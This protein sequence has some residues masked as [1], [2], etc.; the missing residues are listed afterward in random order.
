MVDPTGK[1]IEE[2]T[3]DLRKGR[4]ST[5]AQTTCNRA[6][7][8]MKGVGRRAEE[9]VSRPGEKR[10]QWNRPMAGVRGNVRT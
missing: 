3:S 9:R 10:R 2:S 6:G 7:Y 4:G 8:E 5:L 1:K